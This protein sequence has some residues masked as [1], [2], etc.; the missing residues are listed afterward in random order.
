MLRFLF[1]NKAVIGLLA[2]MAALIMIV[3]YTSS[4]WFLRGMWG[5]APAETEFGYQRTAAVTTFFAGHGKAVEQKVASILSGKQDYFQRVAYVTD[6]SGEYM[7]LIPRLRYQ[8]A[9]KAH[10]RASGWHVSRT[11]WILVASRARSEAGASMRGY[12]LWGGVIAQAK[13]L[14]YDKLPLSPLFLF[15]TQQAGISPIAIYASE[16][17][18]GVTGTASI[19]AFEFTASDQNKNLTQELSNDDTL[20]VALPSNVLSIMNADFIE[21]LERS[22]AQSLH[23]Q[24][25]TPALL[26]SLP[27]NEDIYLIRNV[28]DIAVGVRTQGEIFGGASV[29][30]MNKEQ[31]QRHPKKKAFTLPDR[32]VGYE[33]VRGAA[34]VGFMPGGTTNGCLPSERYDETL[35]LCGKQEAAV[36]ASSEYIGS[37]LIDFMTSVGA[38][39]WRG[40][41]PGEYPLS[42][43]GSDKAIRFWIG[44]K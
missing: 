36:L 39:G 37:K 31:G 6:G 43:S 11:G 34:D 29:N 8:F 41:V 24:K 35:F 21:A 38:G 27:P 22:I 13:A 14:G 20:I 23:F 30:A 9:A 15:R 2:G 25:T 33:Y 18:A 40:Y 44:K 1:S 10:L 12:S 4:L 19:D 5:S 26:S 7:A 3:G 17:A 16:E 28:A 42:F 32:S